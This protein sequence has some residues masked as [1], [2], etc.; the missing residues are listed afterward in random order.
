MDIRDQWW[1]GYLFAL[2]AHLVF[3]IVTPVA[4]LL[5]A[6]LGP[7]YL[8]QD[9]TLCPQCAYCLIGNESTVCPECGRPFTFDELDTTEA[10]FREKSRLVRAAD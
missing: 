4:A 5:C 1:I 7:R 8:L 9:G 6:L 10:A 3:W 2:G